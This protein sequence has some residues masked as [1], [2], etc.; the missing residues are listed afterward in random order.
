MQIKKFDNLVLFINESADFVEQ[1]CKPIDG[2]IKIALSGG[3]TPKPIY[4]NL[5]L[6]EMPFERIEF[7]QV[8]ER[9]V[10]KKDF[11]SN[12]AMI[13]ESFKK[14]NLGSFY[15]FDTDLPI[16]DCLKKYASELPQQFDLAILG[17]GN[18]GHVASVFPYSPA[19]G[20]NAKVAHTLTDDF[21]IKD[22]LTVTL[23]MILK[24]KK[25]LLLLNNKK[26]ALDELLNG[27]KTVE[28]FPAKALLN[29]SDFTIN[30]CNP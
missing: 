21:D 8:D 30:Y 16:D 5:A 29:H 27:T 14:S 20:I 17:M 4:G 1:A 18:D 24:S 6:R 23:P 11:S 15:Y 2:S 26:A 7:F 28:E 9:Y 3:S 25:L 10:D 12:Y 22:R 19:I 13:I